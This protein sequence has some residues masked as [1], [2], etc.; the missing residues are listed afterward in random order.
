MKTTRPK[1]KAST[2]RPDP[3]GPDDRAPGIIEP[4]ALYRLS[5]IK[6]RLSWGNRALAAAKRPGRNG[7]PPLRIIR[8]GRVAYVRGDSILEFFS[9]LER[10]QWPED[11]GR[12][13]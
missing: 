13:S 12:Q 2:L 6:R 11:G 9:H 7:R 1:G 3:Q 4:G 8:F 10:E 5:E